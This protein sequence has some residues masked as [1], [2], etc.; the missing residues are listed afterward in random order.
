MKIMLNIFLPILT[1]GILSA[2]NSV[3]AQT[4]GASEQFIG[5]GGHV[6]RDRVR[7]SVV[8]DFEVNDRVSFDAA[9]STTFDFTARGNA[10]YSVREDLKFGIGFLHYD[11]GIGNETGPRVSASYQFLNNDRWSLSVLAGREF[12]FDDNDFLGFRVHFNASERLSFYFHVQA[13]FGSIYSEDY[14]GVGYR[15]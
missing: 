7:P 2:T 11:W 1:I 13:N 15:F 9:V 5:V 12:V 3:A 14:F 6:I 4:S 10:Y 8:L